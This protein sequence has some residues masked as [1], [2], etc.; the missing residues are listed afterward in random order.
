MA[1]TCTV[2][3]IGALSR[4][5]FWNETQPRRLAHST[6]VLLKDP[7]TTILVDPGLP[8]EMLA[9]RLDERTGLTPAQIDV[10]FLTCFR[11]VHRR[12][13]AMF[14]R[15]TWLMHEPE[16]EA[17]A[18]HLGRLAAAAEQ[19]VD[20]DPGAPERD[21]SE[22][23]EDI[24]RQERDLLGRIHPADDQLTRQIHLFPSPGVTPGCAGLLVNEPTRCAIVAG[25]AMVSHEYYEVGRV[26]EQVYDL[27]AARASF[28]DILEVAD[29]IIPGHDCLF[30]AGR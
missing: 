15:A 8:A 9:Q 1:V 6:T 20:A 2:V 29:V 14:D 4:N 27:E 12:S 25:D 13:L 24:V 17:V 18:E 22:S 30:F 19:D 28:R 10:V 5:R 11:P 7:G 3:S 26:Y 23:V 16:I 21:S